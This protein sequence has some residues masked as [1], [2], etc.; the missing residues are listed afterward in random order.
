MYAGTTLLAPRQVL[1]ENMQTN[2]QLQLHHEKEKK[3]SCAVF[4]CFSQNKIK[5][6]LCQQLDNSCFIHQ[7]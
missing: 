1:N 2:N 7:M 6:E 4:L 3:A 5:K